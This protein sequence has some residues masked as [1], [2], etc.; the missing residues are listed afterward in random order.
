MP[1]YRWPTWSSMSSTTIGIVTCRA[2]QHRRDTSSR[3]ALA[4]GCRMLMPAR[5]LDSM[6]QPSVGCASRTYTARKFA[7]ARYW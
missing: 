3:S 2:L 1:L 4:F 7:R 6:R 5:S